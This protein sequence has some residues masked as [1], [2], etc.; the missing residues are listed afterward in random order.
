MGNSI[1]AIY[2]KGYWF[3]SFAKNMGKS[4]SNKYSQKLLDS[5]KKSTTE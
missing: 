5:A 3:L 4:L 1:E 2:V